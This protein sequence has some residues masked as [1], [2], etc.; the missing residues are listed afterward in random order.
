MP[1]KHVYALCIMNATRIDICCSENECV[2]LLI[3]LY[4]V[5]L[6]YAESELELE[7]DLC[8]DTVT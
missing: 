5:L 1:P 6:Q 4:N 7:L 3:S 2:I 8:S